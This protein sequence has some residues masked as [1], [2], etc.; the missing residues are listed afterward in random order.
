MWDHWSEACQF[1]NDNFDKQTI[2]K[3]KDPF[4]F[5]FLFSRFQILELFIKFFQLCVYAI[6]KRHITASHSIY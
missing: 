2:T 5:L 4:R 6:S 1:S 3:A